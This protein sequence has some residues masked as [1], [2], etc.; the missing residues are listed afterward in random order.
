MLRFPVV[1]GVGVG[2]CGGLSFQ[3]RFAQ[4]Q[5]FL[6]GFPEGIFFTIRELDFFVAFAADGMDLA[7]AFSGEI[8]FRVTVVVKLIGFLSAERASFSVLSVHR[9]FC[10]LPGR[11]FE[12]LGVGVESE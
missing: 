4:Y 11:G 9:S 6:L 1:G 3:K 8:N 10:S 7:E 12:I 2:F 5:E